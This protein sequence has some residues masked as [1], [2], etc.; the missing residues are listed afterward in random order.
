M[1]TVDAKFEISLPLRENC[2]FPNNKSQIYSRFLGLQRRFEKDESLFK[3]YSNFMNDMI[4]NKYVEKVDSSNDDPTDQIWY[5]SHH[6]VYH[7]VK[8]KLRVVFNCSLKYKGTSLND[9][10]LQGPDL[11]NSLFGVLTRFR[12][13]SIA[14]AADIKSMFYQVRVPENEANLMRFFWY[15]STDKNIVQYRLR[16]HVFGA[17]SSPSIANFALRQTCT[18]TCNEETKNSINKNFYVDDLLKSACNVE[19]AINVASDIRTTLSRG[20]FN[21]R[22]FTGNSSQFQKIFSNSDLE[23]KVF[24]NKSDLNYCESETTALGI[25][26]NIENDSLSL[27]FTI[28]PHC[29][30]TKR[31]I[32]RTLAKI[33]DPLGICSPAL[34]PAKKIFQECC[35]L[36]VGW[37]DEVPEEVQNNWRQW[38]AQLD[39]LPSYSVARCLKLDFP[40]SSYEMHVFADGSETAYG[41]VAY[42]KTTYSNGQVSVNL[43][44]SKSRVTPINNRTLKTVPRIELCSARLS[45][46]LAFSIKTELEYPIESTFLL[47]R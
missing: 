12:Q 18:L 43:I 31:N 47:D 37:D 39:G 20:G 13:E 28:N 3:D 17:T 33:Y 7:K 26:W 27:K 29:S 46:E 16:V 1:K 38:L 36:Q 30:I 6:P 8:N 34:I 41:S 14:F 32:L 35:K 21:L 45:V 24:S 23:E 9:N 25:I 15:D 11:A 2:T 44:A 40:V 10:L 4:G 22:S 5:L 19:S 42:V